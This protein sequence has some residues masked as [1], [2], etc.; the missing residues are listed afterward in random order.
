MMWQY[1]QTLYLKTHCVARGL[2]AT[3]IASYG[4][5]LRQFHAFVEGRLGDKPPAAVTARDV[6]EYLEHLRAERKNGP[7]AVSLH[8]VVLKNFYRALVAMHHLEL[9]E[10]PLAHF[11]KVKA[12]PVKLPVF[13][14]EDEVRR[15][16]TAPPGDTV[17]A[18]RD[19]ALL[20]LLYGTGLRASECAALDDDDV[21]LA[22]KTVT[23]TGK[24][25]HRRTVPL[26]GQVLRALQ[27][28]RQVR[29]E[30]DR[31]S[32]FFLNLRHRRISRGAVYE[33][34]RKWAAT[35]KIEKRVSPHRLRHT[36]ATH[37]V[38]AGVQIVTIRDLLG[39][40]QIS[41]TQVYLHVTA[42]DL[43]E[44]AERHPIE[45][46]GAELTE[47]LPNVKLPWHHP[48]QHHRGAG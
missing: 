28:Y 37:L 46:L 41:S 30:V 7:G 6:L 8:V 44:A 36:F 26:N 42:T 14:S 48:P 32:P 9:A 38:K 24:G 2:R 16:L 35:A 11:P 22:N 1:A 34:V 10:N 33:R 47:L 17:L 31:H 43:R 20:T 5:I 4:A 23:V 13:L 18:V 45:R 25:G 39:H 12:A 40:R 21:D 15:L 27:A 29:G 3:T 19:R